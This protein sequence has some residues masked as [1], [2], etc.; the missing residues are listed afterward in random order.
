MDKKILSR[1]ISIGVSSS[2]LLLALHGTALATS[3]P[4]LD[5]GTAAGGLTL[6][7][8]AALLV[9]ERFRRR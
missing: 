1:L 4:E 6:A 8:G 9:I 3:V 7:V 2:L 5:P